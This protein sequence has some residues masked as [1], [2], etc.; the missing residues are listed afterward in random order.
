MEPTIN[1]SIYMVV[2]FPMSAQNLELVLAV[3]NHF[4]LVSRNVKDVDGK[5]VTV[6]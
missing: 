6:E 5:K 1:S 4:D 3:A 2:V